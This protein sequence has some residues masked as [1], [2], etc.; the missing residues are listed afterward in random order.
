MDHDDDHREEVQG[1]H[2]RAALHDL[3]PGSPSS[4]QKLQRTKGVGS[5]GS[6][7]L[8]RQPSCL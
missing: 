2:V 7:S 8:L 1:Y 6:E 4:M 3:Q 5:L